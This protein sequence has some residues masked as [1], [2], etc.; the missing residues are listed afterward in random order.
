VTTPP[1]TTVSYTSNS[2]NW[3]TAVGGSSRTHDDN[4][5]LLSDGTYDYYYD[6][7]NNL[8]KV[9]ENSTVVAE[10]E[11]DALGRRVRK[12][13]NGWTDYEEYYYDGEHAVEEYDDSDNLLKKFVY[14]QEIDEIRVMIAPDYADVDDDQNTTEILNF[15]FHHN[16]LGSV[17]HVTGEDQSLV[18]QYE[19]Q[20]YGGTTIKD[21]NGTD[22]S[23]TSA[24]KNPYLFT[25]RRYEEETELYHYRRRAYCPNKGRFLQRDPLGHI[26]GPNLFTYCLSCPTKYSDRRG[27][28]ASWRHAKLTRLAA[29]KLG[30]SAAAAKIMGEGSVSVDSDHKGEAHH[31]A[32][33]ERGESS[34]GA[35]AAGADKVSDAFLQDAL[36]AALNGN[37][38]GALKH[39]G[40]ALHPQQDKPYHRDLELYEHGSSVVDFL[41]PPGAF[42]CQ[43]ITHT[44]ELIIGAITCLDYA[45]QEAIDNSQALIRKFKK[46][47]TSRGIEGLIALCRME[48]YPKG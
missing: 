24:I 35:G 3:Y 44:R 38:A 11:F 13:T 29:K 46:M 26:D 14:G 7:R 2:V 23:G 10:Y 16:M 36:A 34:P 9:E 17:T 30:F 15:Y 28:A 18:E 37:I 8:V 33:P 45:E 1:G 20:P 21:G 40:K 19:Y 12:S 22:L 25:A 4:G 5:N 42:I 39:L 47:L 32:Q 41:W 31:H 6:Y 27:T 48:A 43:A